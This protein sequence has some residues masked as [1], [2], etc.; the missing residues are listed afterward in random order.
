MKQVLCALH[1]VEDMPLVMPLAL[2][3]ISL[4]VSLGREAARGFV[5]DAGVSWRGPW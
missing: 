1:A 2:F 3:I 5:C 4:S